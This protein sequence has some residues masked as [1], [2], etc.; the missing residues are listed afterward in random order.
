MKPIILWGRRRAAVPSADATVK[1][2]V[3]PPPHVPGR[4]TLAS[5]DEMARRFTYVP[6]LVSCCIKRLLAYPDQIHLA[7]SNRI[8]YDQPTSPQDYDALKAL[9]PSYIPGAVDFRMV[10]PRLWAI[11]VQ[12]YKNLPEIFSVYSIPLSDQYLPL[13]QCIPCTEKFSLI[14]AL[15]LSRCPEIDDDTIRELI[16]LKTLAALDIGY[17]TISSFGIRRLALGDSGPP[18]PLRVLLLQGCRSVDHTIFQYLEKYPLLSVIDLRGTKCGSVP[19]VSPFR[20][21]YTLREIPPFERD[22]TLRPPGIYPRGFL[23]QTLAELRHISESSERCNVLPLSVSQIDA[24]PSHRMFYSSPNVYTLHITELRHPDLP[25]RPGEA[26][27]GTAMSSSRSSVNR[28]NTFVALPPPHAAGTYVVGASEDIDPDK[29]EDNTRSR[30]RKTGR[31]ECT[32]DW[33][34]YMGLR[35]RSPNRKP[36]YT[37]GDYLPGFSLHENNEAFSKHNRDSACYFGDN[38]RFQGDDYVEVFAID[39]EGLLDDFNLQ[40]MEAVANHESQA[41]RTLNNA[42][43]FYAEP[44]RIHRSASASKDVDFKSI[45]EQNALSRQ[46]LYRPP[47]PWAELLRDRTQAASSSASPSTSVSATTSPVKS[48][49]TSRAK[50]DLAHINKDVL[51]KRRAALQSHAHTTFQIQ[52]KTS[53]T[54]GRDPPPPKEIRNPFSK[55]LQSATGAVV[56]RKRSSTQMPDGAGAFTEAKRRRSNAGVPMH[57]FD[58][59]NRSSSSPELPS[60][61]SMS[62]LSGRPRE[63]S[64]IQTHASGRAQRAPAESLYPEMIA[65]ANMPD[66]SHTSNDTSDGRSTVSNHSSKELRPISALPV[67]VLP[68]SLRTPKPKPTTPELGSIRH[69]FEKVR[70]RAAETQA[71]KAAKT[72]KTAE[73]GG[74]TISRMKEHA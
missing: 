22:K 56:D 62:A 51:G 12:V 31:G 21:Y 52:K 72:A 60:A 48:L 65:H 63:P 37:P 33:S 66:V 35:G 59:G 74:S 40:L 69:A 64:S 8:C 71:S 30:K 41:E 9:I 11:I 68:R 17:T 28:E 20:P 70:Q 46:I 27:A 42:I 19:G 36:R 1:V 45:R 34:D 58:N 49:A 32:D 13:L 50:S 6:S 10:D 54:S 29:A 2:S 57:R 53:Q 25:G 24:Q 15:E 3:P 61:S 43:S 7:G 26:P 47:P 4:Y 67:P 16:Q 5:E 39:S 44:K 23:L 55:R 18:V 73:S 38:N 14:T